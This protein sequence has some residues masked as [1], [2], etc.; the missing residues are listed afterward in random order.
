MAIDKLSFCSARPSGARRTIARLATL[1]GSCV[2]RWPPVTARCLTVP[3]VT[4]QCSTDATSRRCAWT[5]AEPGRLTS[6]LVGQHSTARLSMILASSGSSSSTAAFHKRTEF[7]T[8]SRA[9]KGQTRNQVT[10]KQKQKQDAHVPENAAA[11]R[12]R[13]PLPRWDQ[14]RT[15][16]L[17]TGPLK[18]E[19]DTTKTKAELPESQARLRHSRQ[20]RVTR[21]AVRCLC[22]HSGLKINIIKQSHATTRRQSP[23]RDGLGQA[24]CV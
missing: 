3:E 14:D 12:V 23:S 10:E 1:P 18:S 21:E 2:T 11:S 13:R 4:V 17:S 7:G 9:G 22:S 6:T 5:R 8:C 19:A 15:P 16:A 24:G 20:L